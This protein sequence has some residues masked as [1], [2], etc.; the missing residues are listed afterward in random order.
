MILCINANAAIDKTVVVSH[1]RLNEIHRPESV[2]SLPGGKG[3]NVAK[4]L[5]R[6][7]E[8]PLISGWVGGHNG[9]SIE[10]G[11]RSEGIETAFVHI[12]AESRTCLSILDPESGGITEIYERG[13]PIPGE[14][15]SE[16][17][18]LFSGLVG[19]CEAVTLSG[20]LPPGVPDDLY[21]QLIEIANG[22]NVPILLDSSG[23]ALRRGVESGGPFLIKPNIG[24]FA[25]LA[26]RGAEEPEEL[27]EVARE[28][29]PVISI[30][31]LHPKWSSS[32]CFQTLPLT[33]TAPRLLSTR[34]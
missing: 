16:F 19:S 7:G 33:P 8:S 30:G 9:R 26:N 15:I 25:E 17:K 31:Q 21:A 28:I 27:R 4:A 34:P 12:E 11:L 20:S 13:D 24:E 18:E 2:L 22:V 6:L 32:V 5:R 3:A 1:F 29:E 14:K 23:E 10:D